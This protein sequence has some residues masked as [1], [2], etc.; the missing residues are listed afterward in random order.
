RHLGRRPARLPLQADRLRRSRMTG[1]TIT[2]L[3]APT[4]SDR[5]NNAQPDWDQ[6]V[7]TDVQGCLL[8]PLS[9]TAGRIGIRGGE[10]RDRGRQAA[11]DALEVFAPAGTDVKNTD[12]IEARGE[13]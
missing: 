9:I 10:V 6:A 7:R 4:V 8:A 12:R 13:T 5:Y 2:I 3:R 11:I 1:E